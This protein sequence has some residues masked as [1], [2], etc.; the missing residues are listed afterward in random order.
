[1]VDVPL[2][3][4]AAKIVEI[5]R[6]TEVESRRGDSAGE[7]MWGAYLRAYRRFLAITQLAREGAGD[8]VMILTRS[9]LNLAARAAWVDV[10]TDPQVRH[11][12]WRTFAKHFHEQ[13]IHSLE[14]LAAAGIEV[15]DAE[16]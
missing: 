7:V 14:G 8:E 9:L 3:P 11:A 2:F 5:V 13:Q 10:P 15:Q 16:S 1:M 6:S 12:R 4:L